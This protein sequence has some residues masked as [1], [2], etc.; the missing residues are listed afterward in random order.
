[1]TR[2]RMEDNSDWPRWL[3]EAWNKDR[4][5]VGSLYP[6]QYPNSDGSDELCIFTLEGVHLVRFDDWIIKGVAGEIY[7]CKPE[8]FSTTYEALE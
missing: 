2:K 4:H 5:A 7:P 3:H 6:S 1:M 8:I